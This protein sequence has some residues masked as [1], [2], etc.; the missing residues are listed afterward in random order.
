MR[1]TYLAGL[2]ESQ[3]PYGLLWISLVP[4][5]RPT[6]ERAPSWTWA[7]IDGPVSY[8]VISADHERYKPEGTL[9]VH[10]VSI[11][12]LRMDA[13]YGSVR[14]EGSICVSSLFKRARVI[15]EGAERS[16]VGAKVRSAWR[17]NF[18]LIHSTM[19]MMS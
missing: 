1:G 11:V 19:M 3:L 17:Q 9:K 10:S 8:D 12:P 4:H 5:T 13:K 14:T 15:E 6:T 16:L 7:S 2:W 18:T